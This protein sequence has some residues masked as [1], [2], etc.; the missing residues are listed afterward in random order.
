MSWEFVHIL[1]AI[2]I[3]FVTILYRR[4]ENWRV[5]KELLTVYLRLNGSKFNTIS[6][7]ESNPDANDDR[8][9][10]QRS[11][12]ARWSAARSVWFVYVI[13]SEQGLVRLGSSSD[14]RAMLNRLRRGASYKLHMVYL[15]LTRADMALK[16]EMAA[17]DALDQR[18]IQPAW[19][20]CAP[21]QAVAAIQA[22]ARDLGYGIIPT[23]LEAVN[24][25]EH[26]VPPVALARIGLTPSRQGPWQAITAGLLAASLLLAAI[27]MSPGLYLH[28]LIDLGV[29]LAT[30]ISFVLSRQRG[31]SGRT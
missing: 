29:L 28:P 30:I 5:R 24:D 22:A 3:Y 21:A 15:G 18:R 25:V 20:D 19:F 12:F 17:K 11:F 16:I 27:R 13:C 26:K 2:I 10:P 6:P 4:G 9:A 23:D 31:L 8:F 1:I 7:E 14:P